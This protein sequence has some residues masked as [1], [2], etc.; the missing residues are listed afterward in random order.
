MVLPLYRAVIVAIARVVH[1]AEFAARTKK[2][3]QE[4]WE[5]QGIV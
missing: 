4:S 1:L 3:D 5:L 2:K